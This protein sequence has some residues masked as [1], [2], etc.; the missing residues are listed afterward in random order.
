MEQRQL[1]PQQIFITASTYSTMRS[2]T[3][4]VKTIQMPKR[5]F[6]TAPSCEAPMQGVSENLSTTCRLFRISSSHIP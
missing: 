1:S 3:V 4:N 2:A 5:G 6:E